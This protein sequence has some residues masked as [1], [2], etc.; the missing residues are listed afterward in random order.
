LKTYGENCLCLFT[1]FSLV[2][3]QIFVNLGTQVHLV[4]LPIVKAIGEA[5][6]TQSLTSIEADLQ[7]GEAIT[8][9]ARLLRAHFLVL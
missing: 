1:D 3:I 8:L 7:V 5:L 2:E 4:V 9:L 6:L